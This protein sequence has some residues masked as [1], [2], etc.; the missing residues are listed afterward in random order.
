QHNGTSAGV[1]QLEHEQIYPQAGWVEHDPKEIWE[2]TQ[3]VTSQVLR[4]NSLTAD[5]IAAV[6]ITN[7][8]ETTVVWD[9]NTGEPVYNAIVWQDTRTQ[10]IVSQWKEEGYEDEIKPKTGLV[11]ATYFSGTKIAWILETVEGARERAERG[12]LLFGNTDTWVIWNLTGGVNG[13]HHITDYTNAS[14]TM[15]FNLENT[16]WDDGILEKLNIPKAML[17]ELRPSSDRETYGS[18]LADGA[19]GG[20]VPIAGDAGDQQAAL[21]GQACFDV[22][23]AKNTYGTGNFLLQNTGQQVVPSKSGLLTTGFYALE[24]GNS[25]YAL[26]G[27]IAI[28]GAAVQWLRDNL[29]MIANAAETEEIAQSVEDA[30]GAYF[31][32]AFSGLFAPYWDERARGVIVGL[33]RYVNRAHLVGATLE[34]ECWQS[35]DVVEAVEQ[36]SGKRLEDLRVDGGSVKN[37]FLM[38]LQADVLGIPVI[39]PQVQETTA[40]GAAYLAGLATGYW[41]SLDEMRENWQVDRTFEPEWSEDQRESGYAQ[42]KKAIERTRGWVD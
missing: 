20:Q 17:P 42:W 34:S 6:G 21:F 28:T 37:N 7:Q 9:K 19:M 40:L 30:G 38:Q 15:L 5:N 36:D 33:T 23:Q 26:E 18:T 25:F 10:P 27:S 32:P 24:K 31:V 29:K 14:R 35:R 2:K 4:D 1:A 8:R 39:R 11:I 13:G 22:G 3:Q 16:D 41:S 12:D